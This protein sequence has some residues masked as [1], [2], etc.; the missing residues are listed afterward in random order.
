M[1]VCVEMFDRLGELGSKLIVL[2]GMSGVV[3]SM[4]AR[5]TEDKNLG[6][7]TVAMICGNLACRP[8]G[9]TSSEIGPSVFCADCIRIVCVDE[10]GSVFF[11]CD[12]DHCSYGLEDR[13]CFY[14]Q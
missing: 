4:M 6:M 9:F 10:C 7:D 12:M 1:T 2:K 11:G 14:D 8:E 5:L 3:V 13:R